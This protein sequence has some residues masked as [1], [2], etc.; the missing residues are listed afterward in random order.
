VASEV[1]ATGALA[2]HFVTTPH[3]YDWTR[4]QT[5]GRAHVLTSKPQRKPNTFC[6]AGDS[7]S[8]EQALKDRE[9]NLEGEKPLG[10]E[11]AQGSPGSPI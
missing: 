3:V 2:G 8:Q 10:G 5:E 6:R 9:M 7:F 1:A 11:E 4:M